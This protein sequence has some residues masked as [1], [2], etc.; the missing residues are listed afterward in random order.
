MK[1]FGALLIL[2][3][4]YVASVSLAQDTNSALDSIRSVALDEAL[5]CIKMA[6]E[7][8]TLRNDYL[9]IDPFRLKKIDELMRNPLE[10][11]SFSEEAGLNLEKGKNSPSALLKS[12]F[13]CLGIKAEMADAREKPESTVDLSLK[14]TDKLPEELKESII[15]LYLGLIDAD[16]SWQEAAKKLSSKETDSLKEYF[17]ILILEDVEDEFKS[18]DELDREQK[19]EEKLTEDLIP[20][21]EK[22]ELGKAYSGNVIL[23]KIVE[24]VTEILEKYLTSTP[25]L[26]PGENDIIFSL[27][28]EYGEILVGGI[29]S[30]IYQGSPR[31]IID[32]GGDDQYNLGSS[33]RSSIILDFGGDD[34]YKSTGDYSIASGFFGTGILIDRAGDDN[35]LGQNFSSGSGLFG[36]G[37]L[38]D[39]EGND[40]YYGDTF[41]Q[42][43]GSF[44]IGILS[45]LKGQD[46]YSGALFAQGFGFVKGFGALINSS[47]ND[48][49]FTGG[50]YKDILRYKDHFISLSQ[51]FAFGIRPVMS[52]GFGFLYDF[53]GNDLYISDIF[54]QGS[55]YWWCLGSL[56]D[57][58]GNDKYISYQYAQ[59]AATHLTLGLLLDKS[60]DDDYISHGV[61]QGCGHDLACGILEDQSGNDNYLSFDL[62]QGAGS[63]NGFGI[64]IDF[65][66][67]DSYLV[68]LKSNTQ[69][70]GNPR[71]DY[72][73]IGLFLDLSGKDKYFGN[74]EDNTWWTTPS[75]WGAG[76]DGEFVKA[77]SE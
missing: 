37:I 52:G 5:K 24:E 72:G 74:G 25:A 44:G 73:S 62:S 61:S 17:P 2:F 54:G 56:V 30:S 55:S 50:K 57:Y 39:Q 15:H 13:K 27:K 48:S 11:S 31:I 41:T 9:K 51:G 35:Y 6:K 14:G 64:Q 40:K 71:R 4:V 67:D 3:S 7:D 21:L 10:I 77:G 46:Q 43:A 58:S 20:L 33:V 65:K 47:G 76:L 1:K 75:M 32:L 36:V 29:S 63:A 34:T 12:G 8:L 49:Y 23:C 19:Y 22:F 18:V 26:K 69:G 68:T 45:D 60:G 16:L 42:G 66:G 38:I 28:T 70:Y 53:A 59:G